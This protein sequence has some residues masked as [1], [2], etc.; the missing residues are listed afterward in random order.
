MNRERTHKQNTP[1]TK[2]LH[3]TGR[4]LF[5]TLAGSNNSLINVPLQ[6]LRDFN[7]YLRTVLY[8]AFKGC[9]L[10]GSQLKLK[11]THFHY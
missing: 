9:G 4:S 3:G 2:Q 8:E 6:R 10:Y 11:R 7:V 5:Q 1:L